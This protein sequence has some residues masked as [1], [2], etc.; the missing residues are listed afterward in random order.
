[1]DALVNAHGVAADSICC[2]PIPATH[3]SLSGLERLWSVSLGN[4]RICVAILDG[5]VDH[6][7]PALRHAELQQIPT[8]VSDSS[9]GGPAA[10]HGTSVASIIFGQHS[11]PVRGV[12]PRCR[13][14]VLPIFVDGP[15]ESIAACSQLDLARAILQ[16][17]QHGAHIINISGGELAPS[18]SAHPLLAD[19]VRHCVRQG[20]LI[21]AAAGNQGCD[22]LHIPGSLPSVLAVGAMDRDGAPL[23]SSNWGGAYQTQGILAPG[24]SILGAV[25]GGGTATNSGTSFA[26]PIVSGVAALLLSI[27]LKLG[28]RPD[29]Q[30]V[31]AA[32]LASAARSSSNSIANQRRLLAGRL[33]IKGAIDLITRG[34]PIMSDAMGTEQNGHSTATEQG[35]LASR[36]IALPESAAEPSL[37]NL[38]DR[39]IAVPEQSDRLAAPAPAAREES[40]PAPRAKA[41]PCCAACAPPQ[42]VYALGQLGYD[43]GSEARRDSI[44]QHMGADSNPHNPEQLLAYLKDN[45]WDAASIIWTLNLDATPVYSVQPAGPFAREICERLSGFLGQQLHEGVERVSIPGRLAG[46]STLMNGQVVPAILPEL[47]GMYSW[48]TRALVEAVCG[49]SSPK[50]PRNG[51]AYAQKLQ[52]VGNFLERVYY[53]SRNLGIT[54]QERALNYAASNALN[55]ERVYEAAMKEQ[56]DLDAIEVE[57]SPVCRPDSDCWD[58]KL[59]FFF[60]QRQVQT[61][62]KAYRF[63]VDVS[64]VVPVMVGRMRSWFVR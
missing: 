64:D 12:A 17:A 47:R 62:R 34:A 46:K 2:S 43:F 20:I 39:S 42:L 61:V 63:T 41:T 18:N 45:P 16:A 44:M 60:P 25:P 7:H 49:N 55:I 36:A 1:L 28:R 10:R 38:A 19:A 57:R 29:P 54:A 40:E 6:S 56:M 37:R 11:G 30:A 13:G 35:S 59:T 4:R 27:Q 52:A 48:T 26:A 58:V 22:C 53:E 24:D 32:I 50:S 3:P 31:R 5:P 8:L 23:D 51:R 33:N 21:V 9:V 14:L 15:G